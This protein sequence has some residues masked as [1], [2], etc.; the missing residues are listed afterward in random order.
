MLAGKLA[1]FAAGLSFDALPEQVV[2]SIKD[3]VM[4]TLGICVAAR[5]VDA[6]R[7]ARAVVEEWGGT[8]D[9]TLIGDPRRRPAASAA[10]F[11][12]TCAHGLDFDDTHLPSI[13]HPSAMLVPGVLARLRS[14]LTTTAPGSSRTS[15]PASRESSCGTAPSSS[16]AS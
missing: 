11:N 2:D 13:V 16:I 15:F 12:G 10:L 14:S 5:D 8:G 6:A 9:S 3:R 1:S 7:S 4:D